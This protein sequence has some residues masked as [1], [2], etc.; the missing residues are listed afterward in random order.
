MSINKVFLPNVDELKLRMC[1]NEEHTVKWLGN[2][3]CYFGSSESQ[4]YVKWIFEEYLPSKNENENN[5][6]K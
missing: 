1:K 6:N 3:D 2:A 5:I 4:E